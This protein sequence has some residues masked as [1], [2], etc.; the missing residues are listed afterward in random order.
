[1]LA[2][3]DRFDVHVRAAC[4]NKLLEL[5]V[6]LFQFFLHLLACLVGVFAENGQG[7]FVLARSQLFELD[8]VFLQYLVQVGYLG[9]DTDRADNRKWGGDDAIGDAGHQVAA[10]G[11]NPVDRDRQR[12]A[13]VAYS[14]Q[15]R[16]RQPVC[17]HRAAAALQA[18]QHLVVFTRQRQQC[19]DLLAHGVDG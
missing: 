12:N 7:P 16:S 5:G 10:A 1:M 9:N 11:G 15:L 6:D 17:V 2:G 3:G 19:G 8:I 18:Y 14:L 4:C 13:V